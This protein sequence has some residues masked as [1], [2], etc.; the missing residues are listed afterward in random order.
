MFQIRMATEEDH[1]S[2]VDFQIKMA[3]ET[4]G[5]VLD[6]KTVGMGVMQ[7]LHNP[8]KGKY[9]VAT[10]NNKVVASLMLTPEWSDWRNRYVLWFQSVYVLPEARKKGV[11]K[12]MYAFVKHHLVLEDE[13]IA[14]L[15]LYVD[16]GNKK[17]IEVYKNVGMDGEHYRVFEWMK[18]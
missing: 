14:G 11:F 3:L 4:E 8:Q 17:A 9:L 5:L 16:A 18:S 6:K 13:Q 1:A 10:I 15:R 7:A 12:K 2:L